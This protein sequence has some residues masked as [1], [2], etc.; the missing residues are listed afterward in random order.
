[1]YNRPVQSSTTLEE[2]EGVLDFVEKLNKITLP[3]QL[4]SALDD[5]LLRTYLMLRHE[6]VPK[7]RI[8]DW[9]STFFHAQVQSE[10]RSEKP[11][12]SLIEVLDKTLSY[13]HYTKVRFLL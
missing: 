9:L 13:V 5:P 11:S 7:H 3:S 6:D 8:D 1:M 2:I 10:Q 4:I 12:N